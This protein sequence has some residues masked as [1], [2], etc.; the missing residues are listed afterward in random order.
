MFQFKNIS[1]L[2]NNI[3]YK[4]HRFKFNKMIFCKLDVKR[5]KI[6]S[7]NMYNKISKNIK[8]YLVNYIKISTTYKC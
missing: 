2:K 7:K 1:S 3:N 8:V 6:E 5:G 4:Y